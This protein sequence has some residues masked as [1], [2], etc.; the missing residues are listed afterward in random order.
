VTSYNRFVE[1]RQLIDNSWSNVDTELLRRHDLIPNLVEVVKGYATH[2]RATFESVINAR[3]AAISADP[4][5][6]GRA[7]AENQLVSGLRKLVAIAEAYPD[8]RASAHFLELQSELTDTENRI[9]AARRIFNGNVRD[10]NR[11]VDSF[12]SMAI[13]R[14]F[15]FEHASYFELDPLVRAAG[16]PIVGL[17]SAGDARH[18]GR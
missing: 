9:Q 4:T 2:E 18:I 17:V 10:Y 15:E 6:A 12:P 5:A 3:Q 1:Q 14:A 16:V 7:D 11:R 8:L 13:A